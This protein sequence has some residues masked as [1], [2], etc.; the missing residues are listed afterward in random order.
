MLTY[1]TNNFSIF[2]GDKK[3]SF[4]PKTFYTTHDSRLLAQ[5]KIFASVAKNLNFSEIFLLNQTHSIKGVHIKSTI[6]AE[7]YQ[8]Y[9][10]EG[11][12][13]I[14]NLHKIGIG[15]VTADCLPILM[16]DQ[17]NHIIAAIH[18]GW[19]GSV[20]LIGPLVVQQ[21]IQ[22]YASDPAQILV[23]FGPSARAC[24]YKVDQAF[25]ENF[26]QFPDNEQSF[27]YH[28]DICFFDLPQFNMIQLQKMGIPA[29]NFNLNYNHC[30]I[31]DLQF[32]SYRRDKEQAF[33]Q[34]T[35]ITLNKI[36]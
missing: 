19:R 18:A 6:D 3:N 32:C 20:N 17:K 31:C 26:T 11:D 30:T 12:Y 33:R 34:A 23:F 24:C 28:N 10:H 5:S 16:Y 29:E 13:L 27:I 7:K 25:R 22:N 2:F 8:P 9:L 1:Q 4:A 36:K 21:L 14:T 15:I 35:V